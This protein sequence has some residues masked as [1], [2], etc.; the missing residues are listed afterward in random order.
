GGD[1]AGPPPVR[2]RGLR[3]RRRGPAPGRSRRLRLCGGQGRQLC[4][5]PLDVGLRGRQPAADLLHHGLRR[6]GE[7]RVV[8]ELGGGL[9]LLL[10]GREQV[11]RQPLALRLDV[12]RTG[13]VQ[14]DGGA[15]DRQRRGGGELLTGRRQ[16]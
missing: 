16:A 3:R 13:E 8:A 12:D 1:G 7:E 15:G 6:L 11:L 14:G 4:G 9:L 5:D 2:T 10:L